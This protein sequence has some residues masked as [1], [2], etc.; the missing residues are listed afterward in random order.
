MHCH[1]KL[2]ISVPH[3]LKQLIEE[4]SHVTPNTSI[5]DWNNF[6]QKRNQINNM[7]NTLKQDYFNTLLKGNERQKKVSI[8][9]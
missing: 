9:F 4:P 8:F 7:K 1:L 5:I 2:K 3:S 6:T